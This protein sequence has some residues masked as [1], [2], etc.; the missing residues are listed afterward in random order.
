[1][2]YASNAFKIKMYNVVNIWPAHLL[3]VH[4]LNVLH[5]TN[6]LQ[7]YFLSLWA[8]LQVIFYYFS[9]SGINEVKIKNV[10]VY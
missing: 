9:K 6:I 2:K 7:I 1:M 3:M 4:I 5:V 8:T 10:V